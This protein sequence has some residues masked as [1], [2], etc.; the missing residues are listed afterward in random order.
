[1]FKKKDADNEYNSI[2]AT[3]VRASQYA[4]GA[5]GGQTGESL[6]RSRG[7]FSTKIHCK[8]DALGYPLRTIL[9]RGEEADIKYAEA[10]FNNEPCDYLLGDRGYDADSFRSILKKNNTTPVIPGRCNRKE[11]IVY[12][13]YIYR[14]RNMIER[15]FNRMKNFRR[16]ATRYDKRAYIFQAFITLF[17]VFKW[18]D[19]F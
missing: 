7:G 19:V 13:K 10:L 2:D 14:E 9:S 18:L 17:C 11:E 5:L 6:G 15:F 4:A 1:M 3:I 8:I 16:L 12:D